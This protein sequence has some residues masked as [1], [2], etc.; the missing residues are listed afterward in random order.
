MKK[1]IPFIGFLIINNAYSDIPKTEF[2]ECSSKNGDLDKIE[3]FDKLAKKHN[4]DGTQTSKNEIQD[5]GKWNISIK[6]NPMDDSKTVNLILL[7]ESGVNYLNDPVFLFIRCKSLKTE[8]YINW[9]NYLGSDAYVTTRIGKETAEKRYWNLST[10]SQATFFPR[11][12][13]DFI[14]K[15]SKVENFVAQVTPY[16][17]SPVTAVFDIKGLENTIEPVRKTCNW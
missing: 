4:L 6:T 14:K 7:A 13:V 2:I 5:S 3:C 16:S 10:D 11:N 1:L 12:D 17:E 8:L 15:L 9:G